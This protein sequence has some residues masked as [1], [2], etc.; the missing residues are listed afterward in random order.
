MNRFCS[1]AK[2]RGGGEEGEMTSQFCF[3]QHL[4]SGANLTMRRVRY[5]MRRN[6]GMRER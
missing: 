4:F 1:E 3:R 5:E 2:I 6:M